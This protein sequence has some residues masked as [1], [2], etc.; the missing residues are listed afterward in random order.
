MSKRSRRDFAGAMV[1]VAI[2]GSLLYVLSQGNHQR[3]K[4]AEPYAEEPVICEASKMIGEKLYHA[5]TS[6]Q[7]TSS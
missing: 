1:L 4:Q 7:T 3:P 2:C 6:S 5:M